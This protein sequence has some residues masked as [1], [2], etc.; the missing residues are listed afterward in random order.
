MAHLLLD[1]IKV[2]SFM[3]NEDGDYVI[4]V[5]AKTSDTLV[6]ILLSILK[7]GAAYMPID[8]RFPRSRVE[9]ILSVSKPLL[10]VYDD[11]Y[12]HKDLLGSFK[13][14][15]V[16]DLSRESTSKNS[17]NIQDDSTL[18][19]ENATQKALVCFTSGSTGVMKGVRFSHF[20]LF[21]RISWQ[22]VSYPFND[23][24]HN[25]VFKTSISFIDH[26]TE[27][28]CPLVS[29]KTL[30]VMANDDPKSL[31]WLMEEKQV[32]RILL[33]PTLLQNILI[34]LNEILENPL[35]KS[36]TRNWLTMR[37]ENIANPLF[38]TDD[39]SK[40]FLS[41]VRLWISSGDVLS[42]DV[43][44]NFFN[45]YATNPGGNMLVNCYG[46]TEALDC[47]SYELQSMN[48][49][50][51]FEQIPLGL[52]AL[53]TTV[54]IMHHDT[55]E[56]AEDGDI[57][58]ICISGMALADGFLSTQDFNAFKQNEYSSNEMNQLIYHT[59]DFGCIKN[60]LVFFEGR[61]DAQIKI[62]GNKINLEE[63]TSIVNKLDYVDDT[64]TL[65]FHPFQPDQK[66]LSVIV[67]KKSWQIEIAEIINEL[68]E[69]LVDYM[70]PSIFIV[71]KFPLMANGKI[72]QQV[73]LWEYEDSLPK[74]K[75]KVHVEYDLSKIP[76]SKFKV[77]RKVF[78]AIGTALG[79]DFN[80]KLTIDSNFFRLGGT[81]LHVIPTVYELCS[82][83]CNITINEFL[84]AK[85]IG[86]IISH[87]SEDKKSESLKVISDVKL[88]MTPLNA[89]EV[90]KC[91]DLLS[92]SYGEKMIFNKYIPNITVDDY[93]H[94]LN[95]TWDH[96]FNGTLSFTVKNQYD[97]VIG[98]T[99]LTDIV[100]KP[101]ILP[102]NAAKE[103]FDYIN[104]IES[105]VM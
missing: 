65:V 99:L 63:V 31:I 34:K 12:P 13:T 96:F 58:E 44:K 25:C 17:E 71:D 21:F 72:D 95:V 6:S 36:E 51:K 70:V 39:S 29:S 26:V 77:A 100:Q 61:D 18:T 11:K 67:I 4:G 32:Q 40:L 89:M 81:S 43:A 75:I 24:E 35:R 47:I 53:N 37:N 98:V 105:T 49:A 60:G 57:G 78:Q 15:K 7:T 91:I 104:D 79:H 23:S 54:Y 55:K 48:Q 20:T 45:Y 3:P 19:K 27:L 64:I 2:S 101:R 9:H 97:V 82:Q 68:S 85:T 92:L 56:L 69:Y 46:L 84:T 42:K 102:V 5:I 66:I 22:S 88:I 8:P 83:D 33:V 94:I 90:H 38:D 52:P 73:L 93:Q 103:I 50:K 41:N 86:E 80:S 10:I 87:V 14:L 76:R 28:W 1:T 30:F 74:E 59:G 16:S 62:N